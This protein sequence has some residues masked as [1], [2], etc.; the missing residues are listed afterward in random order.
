[1]YTVTILSHPEQRSLTLGQITIT[2]DHWQGGEITW[3]AEHEAASFHIPTL[4]DDQWQV[5]QDYQ[6]EQIDMTIQPGYAA[7]KAML[8][9]DM[10]STMIHQE[11]L[12]EMAELAGVGDYVRDVTMRAMNGEIQFEEALKERVALLKGQSV[13]IIDQIISS[14]LSFMPGGATLLATMR[15]NGSYAALVSGGFTPFTSYVAEQLGFDEHHGN[16]LIISDGMLTGEVAPPI[17]GKD[18]K[19]QALINIS[20]RLGLSHDQVMAVGDGANDLDMIAAAG[21][22]VAFHAK[23]SVAAAAQYRLNHGDLT[24]LLYLQGYRKASFFRP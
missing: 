2:R 16:R 13:S 19:R 12:D 7:P 17:Q 4:P 9:A 1:M 21:I 6:N 20:S 11:C 3:L 5:W 18:A 15:R 10:D 14:R 24:A 8:I 23:P 22:G